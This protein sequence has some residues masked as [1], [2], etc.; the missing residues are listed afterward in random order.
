MLSLNRSYHLSWILKGLGRESWIIIGC[1]SVDLTKC[2]RN[3]FIAH[4]SHTVPEESMAE[5]GSINWRAIKHTTA[6]FNI[7][8]INIILEHKIKIQNK[9]WGKRHKPRLSWA[10]RNI[11]VSLALD[12][13]AGF[14]KG[15]IS[16]DLCFTG[17]HLRLQSPSRY[18]RKNL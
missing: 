1:F 10:N 18:G 11:W 13:A 4:T 3:L 12:T 14:K 2:Q 6:Y 8:V 16:L 15:I 9:C 5:A 17:I 7:N